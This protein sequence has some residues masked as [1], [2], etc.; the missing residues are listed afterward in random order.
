[1]TTPQ[2]MNLDKS[3]PGVPNC[4]YRISI[5][6]LVLNETRDKFLVCQEDN[7]MWE[8][9]GGGLDWGETPHTDLPR[10][11]A[12][13]MGLKTTSIADHPSYFFTCTPD[14]NQLIKYAYVLYE[15]TLESLDFT[16]GEECIAVD[17]ISKENASEFDL[18]PNVEIFVDIF[19]PERHTRKS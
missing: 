19:D 10:E 6:A 3:K 8:L 14:D 7:K 16:P 2:D 9:P 18:V 17:W 13:E 4:Y 11:I 15:T 5:K 12:E 1:M